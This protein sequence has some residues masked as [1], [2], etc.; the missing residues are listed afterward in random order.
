MSEQPQGSAITLSAA[1]VRHLDEVCDAFEKHWLA[2]RPVPIEEALAKTEGALR[3]ALLRELLR[4]ELHYRRQTGAAPALEEYLSRFPT[5]ADFLR[6]LFAPTRRQRLPPE[7]WPRI[8]GYEILEHIAGGGQG[9]VFRARQLGLD[10]IVALKTLRESSED[11]A[12]RLARFRREGKLCAR[13]DHPNI[14]RVHTFDVH[15]GTLYLTMEYAEG[16]SLKER[17]ERER[18]LAPTAA[19]ELLLALAQ[20]VDHA[21]QKNII[22]RDLKPGNVLF[23]T[24][25]LAKIGDFG[26]AKCLAGDGV[27]LTPA[28]AILGSL[29]YMAP[30]Q[31][32]GKTAE[33]GKATDVY[34][35]GAILYEAL[36]GR[37]PFVGDCEAAILYNV[38][39]EPL[40]PPSALQSGIPHPLEWICLKC[41][42]KDPAG[43]FAD[44]GELVAHLRRFLE[45]AEFDTVTTPVPGQICA[46]LED[47]DALHPSVMTIVPSI[48]EREPSPAGRRSPPRQFPDIPGY[49]ILAVLGRGGMGVVYKAIQLKLKRL[50][51]LKTIHESSGGTAR[52]RRLLQMEGELAAA[53]NHPNIV[54]VLD[55]GESAG[56]FYIAME[57]VEGPTLRQVLHRQGALPPRVAAELLE[58]LARAAGFFHRRGII[59]RDIKPSN[60]LLDTSLGG[61]HGEEWVSE[62]RAEVWYGWPKISDF[63]LARRVR[64]SADAP[65]LSANSLPHGEADAAGPEHLADCT[66]QGAI[67][68]TPAYMSP[69]QAHGELLVGPS[70]DV[71]SLG[72]ILYEMLAGKL[73][74]QGATVL[75]LLRQVLEATVQPPGKIRPGLPA[76]LEAI[77]LKC[78]CKEPGERYA[79]GLELADD[80]RSFLDGRPTTVAKPSLWKRLFRLGT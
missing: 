47:P 12:V 5:E 78:L 63:G 18:P 67:V 31:A 42:H 27:S 39:Y 45:N 17:L 24:G 13:L 53:L 48:G 58:P 34:G 36:T 20:A 72:M 8:A 25:G 43:R 4:L 79:T 41:L 57:F 69:E 37:P 54:Q 1:E 11:D 76:V 59:H 49:R 14:I 7:K 22:H 75:D 71:W 46:T 15:D 38:C 64:R 56:L 32:R 66:M 62:T 52:V 74:F 51:A 16:G 44:A 60:V 55:L 40:V 9:H 65:G 26:L 68:G 28:S 23:T 35:L 6:Q 21:H 70:L 2:G 19:A 80:L 33:I 29:N 3:M 77:C 30:E 73:P 10:R 50:V 61:T